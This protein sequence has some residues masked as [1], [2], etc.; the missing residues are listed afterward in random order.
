MALRIPDAQEGRDGLYLVAAYALIAERNVELA[1]LWEELATI[2]DH[3]PWRSHVIAGGNTN[4][5]PIRGG[6]KEYA[7]AVGPHAPATNYI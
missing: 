4:A 5:V 3:A 1:W 2:I 6:H 7:Q